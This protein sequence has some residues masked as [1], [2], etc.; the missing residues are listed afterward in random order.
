MCILP[1][2]F[3]RS[4]STVTLITQKNAGQKLIYSVWMLRFLLALFLTLGIRTGLS[5]WMLYYLN[6]FGKAGVIPC[7]PL[8]LAFIFLNYKGGENVNFFIFLWTRICCVLN[9]FSFLFRLGTTVQETEPQKISIFEFSFLILCVFFILYCQI[10]GL[11]QSLKM[12]FYLFEFQ[13]PKLYL[14]VSS[15]FHW[16]LSNNFHSNGSEF[17]FWPVYTELKSQMPIQIL[18]VT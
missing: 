18:L 4:S 16:S 11:E 2:V 10:V 14:S 13:S 9:P 3:T 5:I 6:V 8:F 17:S 1:F 15:G 12:R 7:I